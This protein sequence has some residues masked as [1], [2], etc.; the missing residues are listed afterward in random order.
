[1][2]YLYFILAILILTNCSQNPS[3]R[4][5]YILVIHGGAGVMDKKDFTPELEK[6][7]TDKLQDALDSGEAILKQGG[8]ALDAVTA[9]VVIMEDSPLFNAG[10][11]SVFSE[12]GENEMD[13][14]IMNGK[15]LSAG[16]V[17][18]IRTIKNPILAARAV[19]EQSP[20]VMLV[21]DG[22]EKFAREHGL[23]I[24]DP[25]YFFTQ[26]RWDAY[27]QAQKHGTVGA[28]ALDRNGN[29][30]AA[31]STG[32]MTN[33]MTGRVGDTPIIG[34]GTYA[35]N[36]TCAVSATGHGEYFIRYSVS[37]DIS[38][39]MEY[40]NLTINEAAHEVIFN[41]LL[42]VG[43]EGGVIAV[44]KNGNYTMTF[45]SS[46]MF[47]GVVTAGGIKEIAIFAADSKQMKN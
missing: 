13:A 32:G 20:H 23:E 43:G 31:T 4:P 39:L 7:Y 27:Q 28:V 29:L 14:A 26:R 12:T 37:Y 1:M 45:N 11:G 33:K 15:D 21:R 41:K 10:K 8:S 34:A 9:A 44:D 30:A 35:N 42:P 47:R 25:S 46:G 24:V 17:A 38:A 19:M 40:K 16:A 18:G 6:A 22:A 36:K 5:E 3:H 2:K